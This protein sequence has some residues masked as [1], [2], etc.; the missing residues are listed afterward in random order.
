[1]YIDYNSFISKY[2]RV[3]FEC[4]FHSFII[5]YCLLPA[6][7]LFSIL[8]ISHLISN[9]IYPT[10]KHLFIF[11]VKIPWLYCFYNFQNPSDLVYSSNAVVQKYVKNP[12]LIGGYKFDLRLYVLVPSFHPLTIYIYQEGLVRFS[13]EKFSLS[14]LKN[15][16]AHLTNS[17]LN[18]FGPGYLETKERV[19]AGT[20]KRNV[21]FMNE[22]KY[23]YI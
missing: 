11:Q 21:Y 2:D 6:L 8:F 20:I 17:S 23:E 1:M 13:T 19:G 4:S 3:Y 10:H 9:L 22:K 14:N 16:F 12:L 18:K 7:L 5:F 15:R